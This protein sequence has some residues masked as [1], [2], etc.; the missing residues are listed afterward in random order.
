MIKLAGISLVI[1]FMLATAMSLLLPSTIIVSRAIDIQTPAPTLYNL[2]RDG[3][4]WRHWMDN[5][6]STNASV[7]SQRYGAI[8]MGS[9]HVVITKVSPKKISSTWQVN[10]GRKMMGDFNIISTRD[11]SRTTLQWAFTQKVKWYPWEK[12]ASI[13][14]DKALGP[15]MEKSL[16]NLKLFAE[17]RN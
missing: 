7:S 17:K 13:L 15:Y 16:D 11:S 8:N 9:T 3:N 5:Y 12:F 1:L 2:V 14:S 4:Q 10:Q 6:D